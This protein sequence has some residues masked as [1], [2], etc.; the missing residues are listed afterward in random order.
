MVSSWLTSVR[1]YK[2][3]GGIPLFDLVGTFFIAWIFQDT[4][5]KKWQWF[6]CSRSYYCSLIPI[7]FITHLVFSVRT[8]LTLALLT[9]EINWQKI[10][11]ALLL[12]GTLLPC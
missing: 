10:V 8:P 1:Q 9:P 5:V 3:V 12:V 2:I 11:F 6:P 4:F 7:A